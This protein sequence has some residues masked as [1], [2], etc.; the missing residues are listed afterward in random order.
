[1]NNAGSDGLCGVILEVIRGRAADD[2]SS[3]S[4][5]DSSSR[6][7]SSRAAH[8]VSYAAVTADYDYC[9]AVCFALVTVG[10]LTVAVRRR[11]LLSTRRQDE[12][13]AGRW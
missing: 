4:R 2:A 1:M 6:L 5:T 13:K 11:R 10:R 7:Q 12:E 8:P 3:L 9:R